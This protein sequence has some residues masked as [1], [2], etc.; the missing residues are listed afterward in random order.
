MLA[1]FAAIGFIARR[2]RD[3]RYHVQRLR[4]A[5]ASTPH[6]RPKALASYRNLWPRP[7]IRAD[8]LKQS[9]SQ[10]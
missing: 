2:R 3:S 8:K 5:E 4:A 10:G 7:I 6:F 1:G 9:R